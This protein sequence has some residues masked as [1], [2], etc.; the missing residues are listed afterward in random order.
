MKQKWNEN[1]QFYKNEEWEEIMLPHTPQIEP[2]D[3]GMHF[4]GVVRYRKKLEVCDTWAGKQIIL[5]LEAVMQAARVFINGQCIAEHKGGYLPVVCDVTK[6][7]SFEGDNWVEVE[8]DNRDDPDI[9]PGKPLARLDYG[10]FGGIYRNAWLIVQ[11]PVSFTHEIL[12]AT[13]AGG[14]VFAVSDAVSEESARIKV[15]A[16]VQNLTPQE[17]EVWV[18]VK[19]QKDNCCAAAEKTKLAVMPQSQKTA[20]FVLDIKMPQLWSPDDPQLYTLQ[21]ETETDGGITDSRSFSIGIRSVRCSR[22]EGFVLN[23]KPIV[24]RGANRHQ[25]YPYLGYAASDQAQYRDAVKYKEGGFNFI[26]FAHYPQSPAFLEACDRLG[27]LVMEPTP[28]WQWCQEGVFKDR[29]KENV[30]DMIRR[31]RNHP[32]VV[33]WE[34]SLNETGDTEGTIF[35]K[36]SGATDDFYCE[37]KET[38][39]KEFPFGILTSG[40][41]L[42]RRDPVK[43]GYDIPYSVFDA[44][45]MSGVLPVP[46]RPGMVREYGDFEFGGN[47]STTRQ[48]RKDGQFAMLLSAWNFQ[49]SHNRNRGCDWCLGDAVWVGADYN[50]GYFPEYPICTCGVMD[51]FRLPKFSY[52]FYRSQQSQT[53]MVYIANYWLDAASASKLVVYSNCDEVELR[54]NGKSVMR[55]KPD[56]GPDTSYQVNHVYADPNYWQHQT[57]IQ[58]AQNRKEDLQ[59]APKSF[60]EGKMFD[61]GNCLHLEH[62]PF[63]F[64][65]VPFEP[66]TLEAVGWIAGE[67]KACFVRK[68][69]GEPAMLK[70]CIDDA[71]IKLSNDGSDFVFVH[72]LVCDQEGTIVP[73]ADNPI[74]FAV[75]NG[76]IVGALSEAAGGVASAMIKT[77][78]HAGEIGIQV[79][80]EGLQGDECTVCWE[81]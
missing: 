29:V 61:G 50:R 21:A 76:C 38:A 39:K 52:F 33:I 73:E 32:C 81:E 35:D 9:P 67:E 79:S 5:E 1:W 11:E 65:N 22:E 54:I 64:E 28:G 16:E 60:A 57:E 6:W 80:A 66:G 2:L 24:L 13:C 41:T 59:D 4:Q 55:Q 72:A 69:P 37:I 58:Q 14:G 18:T 48:S 42:G 19:L 56:H 20:E 8:A 17:K 27:I 7:V 75:E 70:L 26:R 36:W 63:T 43:V 23:G 47:Y 49:W 51:L 62:P 53:P 78:P 31:D 12:S 71:G 40:D 25:Q 10:Y 45:K 44:A 74:H 68:T 34:L 77:L 15:F 3:V 46:N 30:R